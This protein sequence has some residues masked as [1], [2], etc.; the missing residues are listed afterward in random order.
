MSKPIT[1][2]K[3]N[4]PKRRPIVPS[5]EEQEQYVGNLAA[6]IDKYLRYIVPCRG[7]PFGIM[8][9]VMGLIFI[10][11]NKAGRL[12][13][14]ENLIWTAQKCSFPMALYLIFL[15]YRLGH[16]LIEKRHGQVDTIFEIKEPKG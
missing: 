3:S 11:D 4:C 2:K 9:V 13:N 16:W 10:Q 8:L 15:L 6:L 7:I 1:I 5:G 14:W 12:T